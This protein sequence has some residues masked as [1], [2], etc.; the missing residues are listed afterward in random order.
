M[1]LYHRVSGPRTESRENP[2]WKIRRQFLQ[3]Q[4]RERFYRVRYRL[5]MNDTP[6]AYILEIVNARRRRRRIEI[7]RFPKSFCK[8]VKRERAIYLPYWLIV[9]KNLE[10]F[11][12]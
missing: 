8:I 10:D 11:I 9:D 1:A 2:V 7:C 6:T 12:I 3:E 4:D 5:L